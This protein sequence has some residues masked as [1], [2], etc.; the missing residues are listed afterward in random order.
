MK[1][2]VLAALILLPAPA[3][4]APAPKPP[5]AVSCL[6]PR[7]I[8]GH[9][10]D[11]D[12]AILFHVGKKTYRNRLAS[13]CPGLSRLNNFGALETEPMGGSQLCEGDSVRILDQQGVRSVGVSAYPRCRLG[14]FEP[15]TAPAKPVRKP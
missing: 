14:W 3:L 4:A 5:G 12:D 10:A 7:N 9:E 8:D 6:D 11:G 15:V 1:A 13:A 2:A